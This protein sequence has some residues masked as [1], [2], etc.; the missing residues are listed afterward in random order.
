MAIFINTCALVSLPTFFGI[1]MYLIFANSVHLDLHFS[2]V[3]SSINS[4]PMIVS[5]SS[6]LENMLLTF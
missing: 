4:F 1:P 3:D 2:L 5:F 6:Q